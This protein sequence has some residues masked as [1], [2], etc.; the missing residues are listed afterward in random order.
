MSSPSDRPGRFFHAWMLARIQDLLAEIEKTGLHP[1]APV[2][3]YGH[4][5]RC[6]ITFSVVPV[7]GAGSAA[8]S[9]LPV[10][11]VDTSG[12]M[13]VQPRLVDTLSA[14]E[15]AVYQV[16]TDDP[17]STKTIARRAGKSLGRTREAVASLCNKELAQRTPKGIRLS[18]G[19]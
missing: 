2:T 3:M 9:A 4:N 15:S 12:R 18:R 16:L 14:L 10:A 1:T 7:D 8:K 6:V 5:E 19:V 11:P 13:L 17:Q